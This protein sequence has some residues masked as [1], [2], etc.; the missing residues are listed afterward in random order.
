[1]P[2]LHSNG[3]EVKGS[4]FSFCLGFALNVQIGMENHVFNPPTLGIWVWRFGIKYKIYFFP[5]N[6]IKCADLRGKSYLPSL[7]PLQ[8]V[9]G[10]ISKKNDFPRN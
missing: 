5:R 1:M 7:T 2:T 6:S 4:G 8:V 9:F 3:L 10:P